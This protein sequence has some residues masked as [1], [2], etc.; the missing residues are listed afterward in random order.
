MPEHDA[1]GR[2]IIKCRLSRE[3]NPDTVTH[4]STNRTQRRLTSLI[5]AND[6]TATPRRH[7][8]LR[9]VVVGHVL[10]SLGPSVCPGRLLASAV[11]LCMDPEP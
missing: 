3:S 9:K 1:L 4:P 6:V 7:L 11:L 10:Q 2:S 8:L 5:E